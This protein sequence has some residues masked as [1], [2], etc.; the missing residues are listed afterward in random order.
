MRRT[1]TVVLT[2]SLCLAGCSELEQGFKMLNGGELSLS[3]ISAGLRQALEK[4]TGN[5]VAELSRAGGYADNRAL[6]IPAPPELDRVAQTLRKV[7]LGA[8][9]DNFESKMNRGA[10]QAAARAKPVFWRAIRE[11]SF[12]DAKGILSGGETAATDYFRATIGDDLAKLYK[13]IVTKAME[14]VGAV[15]AYNDLVKR[16]NALPLTKKPVLDL[17]SYA[18]QKAMDGLFSVVAREEKA[19]RENPAARTTDLLRKVFAKQ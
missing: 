15:T 12:A 6:R 1:C 3:T 13:P 5:A 17:E 8:L 4:G 9:V 10:E 11:M 18:T 7:G 19:I 2:F 16:Y 14:G